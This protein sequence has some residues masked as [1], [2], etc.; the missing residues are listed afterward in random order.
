ME[1]VSGGA[2]N[3]GYLK[4]SG[5]TECKVRGFSLNYVALQTLNYQTMKDNILKELDD[6]QDQRR[7]ME[8]VTPNFFERNK[9]TKRIRQIETVKRYE[10]DF[11]KRVIYRTTCVSYPYGYNW[12][13]DDVELL[14][15]L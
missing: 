11:D 13:D 14:L 7:N 4:R 5:K 15:S 10:L 12:F 8:I 1:F 2:K 6:P 9:T 3:Y